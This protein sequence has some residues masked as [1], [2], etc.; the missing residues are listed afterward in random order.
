M[1]FHE[2]PGCCLE[3]HD[4]VG[5]ELEVRP[6]SGTV[7]SSIK[8]KFIKR[9]YKVILNKTYIRTILLMLR[10]RGKG[11]WGCNAE[12]FDLAILYYDYIELR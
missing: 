1:R 5:V 6:P 12:S 10:Y 2:G 7:V 8:H 9:E 3:L 11:K 4:F